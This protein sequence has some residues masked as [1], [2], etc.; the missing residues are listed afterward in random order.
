MNEANKEEYKA[1]YTGRNHENYK[2]HK[3]SIL[4]QQKIKYQQQKEARE[5]EISSESD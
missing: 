1:Y 5:S 4:A 2:K 3:L